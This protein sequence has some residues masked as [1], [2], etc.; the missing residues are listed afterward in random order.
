LSWKP[1]GK[2][3]EVIARFTSPLVIKQCDDDNEDG[4]DTNVTVRLREEVCLSQEQKQ[5]SMK[6]SRAAVPETV[7]FIINPS[8]AC[9]LRDAPPV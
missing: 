2:K 9:W 8:K 3:R 7:E 4:N 6:S 1:A 5:H